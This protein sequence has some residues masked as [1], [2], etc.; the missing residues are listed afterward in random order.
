MQGSLS[1]RAEPGRTAC[2]MYCRV[3]PS[4]CR[5]STLRASA[6]RTPS[7]N[8]ASGPCR[9]CGLSDAGLLA[10]S[11][12]ALPDPELLAVSERVLRGS[13]LLAPWLGELAAEALCMCVSEL[14]SE[15]LLASCRH[16]TSC[17]RPALD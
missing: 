4:T 15:P 7:S 16:T 14:C 13:E 11:E 10:V 9:C 3:M 17:Q 2:S 1:S 5:L 6:T 12:N 8:P